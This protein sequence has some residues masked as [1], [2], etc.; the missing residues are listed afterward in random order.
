LYHNALQIV[1]LPFTKQLVDTV[2]IVEDFGLESCFS[3]AMLASIVRH[4]ETLP[5]K[6]GVFDHDIICVCFHSLYLLLDYDHQMAWKYG[7][8]QLLMV[9]LGGFH[10][11]VEV[12]NSTHA[13]IHINIT[14]FRAATDSYHHE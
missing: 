1:S 9:E 12:G 10:R 5:L 13:S 3:L 8:N 2:T 6:F 11:S 14:C 7:V 4:I